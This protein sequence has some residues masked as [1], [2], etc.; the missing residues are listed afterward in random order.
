VELYVAAAVALLV[1]G[2][3]ATALLDS[4]PDPVSPAVAADSVPVVVEPP[5]AASSASAPALDLPKS[6]K[7]RI[8]TEPKDVDVFLGE[9]RI[10]RS[11]DVL[12]IPR[13]GREVTLRLERRGYRSKEIKL[14]PSD[15]LSL[16]A[17]LDRAAPPRQ[18]GH[19]DLEPPL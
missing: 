4:E 11:R 2:M 17:T 13:G 19:P 10:G 16:E 9:E 14:T 18:V 7:L 15:D 6:V 8:R 12:E 3:A 5:P 1:A